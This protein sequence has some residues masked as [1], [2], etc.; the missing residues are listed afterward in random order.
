MIN[1]Y[2]ALLAGLCVTALAIL[3]VW[4][5]KPLLKYF[6]RNKA[7][8]ERIYIE[9][10]LKHLFDRKYRKIATTIESISGS[11]NI[12]RNHAAQ[13]LSKLESQKLIQ[14]QKNDFQ[15]TRAG[16]SHALRIIRINRLWE[17]YFADKTGFA[18]TEWHSLAEVQEHFTTHEEAE[19][20]AQQMGNPGFDPHG[21]PIPTPDG[22]LPPKAGKS[23]ADLE[24]NN[25]ARIMNIEDEPEAVFSELT[26][27]GLYPGLQVCVINRSPEFVTLSVNNQEL[28]ISPLAAANV[29]VSLVDRPESDGKNDQVLSCLAIG[30]SGTVTRISHA[31]RGLQR[32]RLLDLGVIPGTKVIAEMGSAGGNPVAYS[33]RGALIALRKEQADNIYILKPEHDN[34][35]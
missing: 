3:V 19:N 5:G 10:A 13:L 32:K 4:Q 8:S 28:Q 23:L 6:S 14:T 9:D 15:L 20:L 26:N 27:A 31:C 24:M 29:T 18:E 35:N 30:E 11:L 17:L 33:I 34:G 22:V 12:S 16:V 25:F 1:P 2:T 7:L 21:A